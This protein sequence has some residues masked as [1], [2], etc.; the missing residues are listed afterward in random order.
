M[1]FHADCCAKMIATTKL[2]N[3]DYTGTGDDPFKNFK[4][5]GFYNQ[6]WILIGF[7][8]RMTDKFGRLASFIERGIL[9]VK[10]ETIEDSLLDLANYCILLCGYIRAFK[11]QKAAKKKA[12]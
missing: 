5:V 7:F 12:A 6:S 2:K 4:A 8:T 1:K 11:T 10:D 9:Y 3:A